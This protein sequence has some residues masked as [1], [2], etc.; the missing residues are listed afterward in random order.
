MG[1]VA[2]VR[3]DGTRFSSLLFAT[4]SVNAFPGEV[5]KAALATINGEYAEVGGYQW[6]FDGLVPKV[7]PEKP[8]D[9]Q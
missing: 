2:V 1:R 4:I 9:E 6:T 3:S 5:R 7:W 8:G